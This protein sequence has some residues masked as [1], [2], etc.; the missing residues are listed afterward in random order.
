[1]FEKPKRFLKG[2]PPPIADHVYDSRIGT[3]TWSADDEAW[4]SDPSHC[5]LGFRF[6]ISGTPEPDKQLIAHAGDIISARD[7][8][9]E[10]ISRFLEEEGK[11]V[12]TLRPYREEMKNL[13][14]ETICLFWPDRPNDGMIFFGGGKDFRS[15]RCDYIG[16]QPTGLGFDSEKTGGEAF[17]SPTR[18]PAVWPKI[19]A[20][21]NWPETYLPSWAT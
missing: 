19:L 16:R 5:N 6:Q 3:L 20:E 14:V 9:V 10:T 1:M 17:R 13:R 15:W 2:N 12:R 8:F 4:L 18:W 21:Q 7:S 11:R